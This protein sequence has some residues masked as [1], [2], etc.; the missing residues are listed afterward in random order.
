[1]VRL[2]KPEQETIIRTS[3]ADSKWFISTH[4]RRMIT[5]LQNRGW[6]KDL[7]LVD[8]C[9]FIEVPYK[10]VTIRTKQCVMN[11]KPRGAKK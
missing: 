2:T 6:G 1:M 8:G 5:L 4:D 3:A 7:E 9:W 10:A 11:P